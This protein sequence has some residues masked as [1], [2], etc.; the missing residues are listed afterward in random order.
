MY[1][2]SSPSRT[3]S[4]RI[5]HVMC[6]S[7]SIAG[8]NQT[9]TPT[10]YSATKRQENPLPSSANG[11]VVGRKEIVVSWGCGGTG[12]R[13]IDITHTREN[14]APLSLLLL[15][16]VALPKSRRRFTS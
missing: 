16:S 1:Q 3:S 11:E 15:A 13:E 14:P 12:P 4:S 9:C 2:H 8:L 10:S 6:P 5:V 7:F